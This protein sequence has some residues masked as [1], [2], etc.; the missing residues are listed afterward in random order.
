M[1]FILIVSI[2]VNMVA[3]LA[4]AI[5]YLRQNRLLQFE[6]DYKEH[7]KEIEEL[8]QMFIIE[9][10]EENNEIKRLF[11]ERKGQEPYAEEPFHPTGIEE[12]IDQNRTEPQK[13]Y[14]QKTALAAYENTR[15][16]SAVNDLMDGKMESDRIDRELDQNQN[17]MLTEA[18]NMKNQGRTI[19]EIAKKMNRGKTEIDLLLKLNRK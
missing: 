19:E 3:V 14:M 2:V 9:M 8:I 17:H 11:V 13:R 7:T 12:I 1:A 18:L 10:K 15:R 6:R 4:I 5:L 16:P